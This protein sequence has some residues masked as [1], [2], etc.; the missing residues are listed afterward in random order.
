[1]PS[2]DRESRV[3]SISSFSRFLAHSFTRSF[4]W[5]LLLSSF[6]HFFSPSCSRCCC[7]WL[8]Q[9]CRATHAI[10]AWSDILGRPT[11]ST[12][13]ATHPVRYFSPLSQVIINEI[14][15][16][17]LMKSNETLLGAFTPVISEISMYKLIS[18]RKRSRCVRERRRFSFL[19]RDRRHRKSV[20]SLLFF[21]F[22]PPIN[23]ETAGCE[24]I[25]RTRSGGE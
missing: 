9:T 11:W 19:C 24:S 23:H 1:M 8:L 7:C 5:R 12:C 15:N 3:E 22:S 17:E 18:R 16:D 2:V 21:S 6:L 13:R 10:S 4:A 25:I 20:A 14:Y